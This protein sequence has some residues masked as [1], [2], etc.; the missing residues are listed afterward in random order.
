MNKFFKAAS[1]VLSAAVLSA[2]VSALASCGNDKPIIGIMQ[3]GTHE[4]LNNCYTGIMKGL[5]EAGITADDYDIQLVNDNF[6]G[7]TA[8]SHAKAFVNKGAAAIVGIATPSAMQAAN[9]SNGEIPVVYCAITDDSVMSNYKNVCGS[10]D[11]PNYEATLELVTSVM[12]KDD[13][14][15]GVIA[16]TAEDSDAVMIKDLQAAATAY[17]GMVIDVKSITDITTIGT[18]TTSMIEADGVDCFLNLLDNTVVGQLDNI[19]AITDK[20]G[21]PV[22]GS[23]VEQVVDGCVAASSIDYIEI[24]RIAGEMAAKILKGESTAEKLGS[25]VISDP[26][27]YYDPAAIKKFNLNV[28]TTLA[29]LLSITDYNK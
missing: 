26:T 21:V 17:E 8:A 5:E 4:S 25:K 15:I 3:F 1:I 29:G 23:E 11:R 7:D 18:L 16:S 19:L 13:L 20:A 6:D 27:P 24:G 2:S 22:F 9:A 10:S 28:P 12:G 14:K